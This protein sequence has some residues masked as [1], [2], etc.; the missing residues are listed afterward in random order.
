MEQ[1]RAGSG[2]RCLHCLSE[3]GSW[4]GEL[5]AGVVLS[6]EEETA[7]ARWFNLAVTPQL[8]RGPANHWAAHWQIFR[9]DTLK[10]ECVTESFCQT[11]SSSLPGWQALCVCARWMFT[12]VFLLKNVEKYTWVPTNWN[13]S[14]YQAGGGSAACASPHSLMDYRTDEVYCCEWNPNGKLNLLHRSWAMSTTKATVT[15]RCFITIQVVKLS[16]V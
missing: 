11:E 14:I 4:V 7:W 5:S 10:P 3:N 8:Q 6:Q 16:D 9:E 1:I 12:Q 13:K 2:T 15:V